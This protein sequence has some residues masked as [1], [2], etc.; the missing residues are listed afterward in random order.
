MIGNRIE[1]TKEF[2]DYQTPDYFAERVCQYIKRELKLEPDIALNQHW[3]GSFIE[4]ENVFTHVKSVFGIEINKDYFD[5]SQKK[6]SQIANKKDVDIQLFNEDIFV[7]DFD[8][9]KNHIS[10]EDNLLIIG[11][12]PW[13]TNSELGS[14]ESENVPIKD[15]FKRLNGMDALTGKSNFD[16]ANTFYCNYWVSLRII[17]VQ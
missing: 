11:N 14:M 3:L 1:I 15:N 9:I 7:F 12:P 2:G 10:K 8:K 17:T 16:I 5:I 4:E 13:V 6:V